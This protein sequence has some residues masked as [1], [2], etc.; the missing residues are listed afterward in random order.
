MPPNLVSAMPCKN[1]AVNKFSAI[2][3]LDMGYIHMETLFTF[4]LGANL[5]L[6]K[7]ILWQFGNAPDNA[8]FI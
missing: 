4:I 5:I 3:I 2:E 1:V 6:T 8:E 7:Q